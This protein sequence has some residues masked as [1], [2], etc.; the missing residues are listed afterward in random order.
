MFGKGARPGG[1]PMTS[2]RPMPN[3]A[4]SGMVMPQQASAGGGGGMFP[5]LSPQKR[6]DMAMEMLRSGMAAAS[7]TSNPLLAFLAPMAGAVIGGG[8]QSRADKAAAAD[9]D[10]MNQTLLG[11]MASDPRAKGYLDILNN[12][13]AP[14]YAKSIAK[15]ALAKIMAPPAAPGGSGGAARRSGR[16]PA[17]TDALLASM[18]YKAG[19]PDSD[20]GEDITPAE[21]ARID[22]VTN[23]R[24]RTSSASVTYGS[25][26]S[27]PLGLE[28]GG[29]EDDPLGI[30]D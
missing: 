8:I 4:T 26:A 23:A 1:A 16:P 7:G 28:G 6:Y 15:D 21:Q 25:T 20:G 22:V 10:A 30:L 27:D 2:P 29:S 19:D 18:L 13:D 24:K 11:S 3:P 14:D 12:P 5:G 9:S 17:N